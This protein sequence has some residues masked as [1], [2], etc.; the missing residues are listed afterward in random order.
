MLILSDQQGIITNAAVAVIILLVL[1]AIFSQPIAR[2]I[3][4]AARANTT[5]YAI[6]LKSLIGHS[7]SF[8]CS[9]FSQTFPPPRTNQTLGVGN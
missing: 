3:V 7:L 4:T 5:L 9:L 1:F 6:N 8:K 2:E